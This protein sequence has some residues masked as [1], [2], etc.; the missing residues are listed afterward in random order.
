MRATTITRAHATVAPPRASARA[1]RSRVDVTATRAA[2]AQTS[3]VRATRARVACRASH[4]DD[5]DELETR[6]A[7]ASRPVALLTAGAR[8]ASALGGAFVPPASAVGPAQPDVSPVPA[9]Q[10]KRPSR[11]LT[12]EA[13]S[14]T[15][16]KLPTKA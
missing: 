5:G 12:A 15:H 11:C 8:L 1:S 6:A 14:N 16:L 7:I 2:S 13:V 9:P 10:P 4:R 3:L